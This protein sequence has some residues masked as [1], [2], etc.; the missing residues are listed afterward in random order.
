MAVYCILYNYADDITAS[1]S[2]DDVDEFVCQLESELRN[3]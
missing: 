3:I 2:S 1:H